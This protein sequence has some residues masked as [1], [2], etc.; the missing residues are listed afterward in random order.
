[1]SLSSSS[2]ST[3]FSSSSSFSVIGTSGLSRFVKGILMI[4]MARGEVVLVIL[5]LC[6]NEREK[7]RRWRVES[8]VFVL[9]CC[10]RK[11]RTQH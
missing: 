5:T 9:S 10:E 11:N 8:H 2:R 1:M 6:V 4:E 3:G 7:F